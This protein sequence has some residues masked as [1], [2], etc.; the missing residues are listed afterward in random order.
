MVNDETIYGFVS[1]YEFFYGFFCKIKNVYSYSD[2]SRLACVTCIVLG[3]TRCSNVLLSMQSFSF[4]NKPSEKS[5][6]CFLF[7]YLA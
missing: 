3:S 4:F 1:D 5:I 7:C 6:L 2:R